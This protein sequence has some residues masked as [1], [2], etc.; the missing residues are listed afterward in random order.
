MYRY[1]DG[2][3]AKTV[4]KGFV[5]AGVLAVIMLNNVW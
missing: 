3:L 4:L 1:F 5:I 2:D